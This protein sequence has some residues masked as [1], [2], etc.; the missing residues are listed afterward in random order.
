[1]TCAQDQRSIKP[2]HSEVGILVYRTRYEAA[3]V[4][5]IAKHVREGCW[6]GGGSLNCRK[7]DFADAALHCEAKDTPNLIH[8]DSPAH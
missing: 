4:P 6:K 7:G 5:P 8:C 3:D 2:G 1:M